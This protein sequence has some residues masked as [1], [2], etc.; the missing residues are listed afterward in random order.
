MNGMLSKKQAILNLAIDMP[1]R[2]GS[3]CLQ[4]HLPKSPVLSWG[5]SRPGEFDDIHA[6]VLGGKVGR[7][8]DWPH[9]FSV[10]P[11]KQ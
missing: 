9:F 8:N 6:R 3:P 5:L 4:P 7:V 2:R 11:I 10:T 1:A